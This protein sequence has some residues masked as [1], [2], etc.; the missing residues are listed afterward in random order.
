MEVFDFNKIK[1]YPYAKRDKNILY[2]ERNFK[3]RI[4]ELPP[5]GKMP[6]CEMNSNVVFFIIEGDAQVKINDEQESITKGQCLITK[7]STL[8]IT[9]QSGVKIMAIQIDAASMEKG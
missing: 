8:S 1:A 7:P 3:V 2:S 9:T 4:I 5:K 6:E